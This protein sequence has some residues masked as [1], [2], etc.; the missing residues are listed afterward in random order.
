VAAD[1]EEEVAEEPEEEPEVVEE[2]LAAILFRRW[3]I[4]SSMSAR[5]ETEAVKSGGVLGSFLL[6]PVASTESPSLQLVGCYGDG[7]VNNSS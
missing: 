6:S 7:S 2:L 5:T 4:F 1:T 3:M